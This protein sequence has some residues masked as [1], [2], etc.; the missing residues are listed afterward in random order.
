MEGEWE[1][2]LADINAALDPRPKGVHLPSHLVG[3]TT[4][5]ADMLKILWQT[6]GE[7]DL[8]LLPPADQPQ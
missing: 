6:L 3:G 8:V 4:R 1:R 5:D 2:L 7:L